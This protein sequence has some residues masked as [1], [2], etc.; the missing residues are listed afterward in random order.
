MKKIIL[1]T[2]IIF[3]AAIFANSPDLNGNKANLL[4]TYSSVSSAQKGSD[5]WEYLGP[6]GGNASDVDISPADPDVWFAAIDEPYISTDGG[7]SWEKINQIHDT[8][9]YCF[10]ATD[11]IVYAGGDVPLGLWYSTDNGSSWQNMELP[12]LA[13]AIKNIVIDP[14]DEQTIYL[15][16]SGNI[17]SDQFNHI[18]KTT[19]AG[20]NWEVLDTEIAAATLGCSDLAVDPNNSNNL[21]AAYYGAFGGGGAYL[22]TD[23]GNSWQD[24]SNNFPTNRPM[25]AVNWQEDYLLLGG[26]HPFGGQTVGLFK[27][28]DAGTSWQDVSLDFPSKFVNCILVNPTNTSEIFV[29]TKGDGVYH[30]QDGGSSWEYSTNGADTFDVYGMDLVATEPQ[31]MAIGCM[32]AAVF[33]SD[34]GGDTWFASNQGICRLNVTDVAVN[35]SNPYQI[36]A[37]FSGDNS[38]GCFL[39]N[40]G[41]FSWQILD[42]IPPTRYSSVLINENGRMYAASSGPSDVAPEGVYISEDGGTTWQ[43]YGPDLGAMFETEIETLYLSKYNS[44]HLYFGGNYFGNYGYDAIIYHS[45]DGGYTWELIYQGEENDSVVDFC[46]TKILEQEYVYAALSSFN[47]GGILRTLD[48]GSNWE[49]CDNGFPTVT[50]GVACAS[51]PSFPET[52]YAVTGTINNYSFYSSSDYGENWNSLAAIPEIK[53]LVVNPFDMQEIF[54][55]SFQNGILYST[56]GGESWQDISDGLLSG[57]LNSLSPVY[58]NGEKYYILVATSDNGI[59]R[60]ELELDVN[61]TSNFPNPQ[62]RLKNYPNPFNPDT[63]I[64]FYLEVDAAVSLAVY[65]AKGQMVKQLANGYFS[66]GNHFVSWN[67]KDSND[68][69]VASG[70][71][72]CRLKSGKIDLI[73]KMILLK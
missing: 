24:I 5:D 43:N 25:H 26:G 10:T 29:G 3:T 2:F 52:M 67:G 65:N 28:T 58:Q 54:A 45:T 73:K 53:E 39:S 47:Q 44:D 42:N 30:S 61:N 72:Y 63:K 66:Q 34:N 55:A 71:Y 7:S 37:A 49:L 32:S 16:L 17:Y 70:I 50:S 23:G 68:Q 27:S 11:S 48:G 36:L 64:N 20:A 19:D 15:C 41:G 9:I 56:N 13:R 59:F 35:P 8:S 6:N 62:T 40:D 57:N 22:S 12:M 69:H 1:V 14:N 18:L 60:R 33:A 38:G 46:E 21:C 31:K 51:L 4:Q